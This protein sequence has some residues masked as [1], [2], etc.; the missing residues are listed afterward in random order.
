LTR[1]TELHQNRGEK[2]AAHV[3]DDAAVSLALGPG[4]R[5]GAGS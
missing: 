4:R 5:T 3:V 2:Q 1:N